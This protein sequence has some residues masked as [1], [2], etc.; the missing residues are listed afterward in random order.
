MS[1]TTAGS[2][3][4]E[5]SPSSSG[6]SADIFLRM[7]RIIFPERVLGSPGTICGVGG[8]CVCVCVC[9]GVC[10]CVCGVCVW[11]RCVYGGGFGYLTVNAIQNSLD[12]SLQ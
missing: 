5:V 1:C 3:R 4:V 12:Y 11:W 7:R 8:G 10:G 2:A 6:L 9:E